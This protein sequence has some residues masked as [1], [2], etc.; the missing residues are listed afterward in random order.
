MGLFSTVI[1]HCPLL[2]EEFMGELQTKDFECMMETYW[3]S[4][5]GR[6]FIIDW[7]DAYRFEENRES[8]S[9]FDKFEWKETGGHGRLRPYRRSVVARMYPARTEIHVFFQGGVMKS[10]LPIDETPGCDY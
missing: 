7:K 5:D 4:P 9:W 10:V 3:L 1:N 8:K 6:L 2:G